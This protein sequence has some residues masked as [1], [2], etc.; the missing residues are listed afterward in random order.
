MIA[1]DTKDLRAREIALGW[2]WSKRT[3]LPNRKQLRNA[4]WRHNVKSRYIFSDQDRDRMRAERVEHA[5]RG[6][7]KQLIS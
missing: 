6:T 7:N 2:I 4:G 5:V 3:A 1:D